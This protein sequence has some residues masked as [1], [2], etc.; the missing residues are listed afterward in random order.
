MSAGSDVVSK[1]FKTKM[2][3]LLKVTMTANQAEKTRNS[4]QIDSSSGENSLSRERCAAY[5]SC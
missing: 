2:S 1:I 4:M 5:L 3:R